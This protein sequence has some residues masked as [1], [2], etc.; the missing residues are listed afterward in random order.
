ME[1]TFQ[2]YWTSRWGQEYRTNGKA[3]EILKNYLD[4]FLLEGKVG[5]NILDIG[6]GAYPISNNF[7]DPNRKQILVD[8][9]GGHWKSERVLKL[10]IDIGDLL[11]KQI[12]RK[13]FLDS[14]RDFFGST[15]SKVVDTCIMGHILNYVDYRAL[16][17]FVSELLAEKGRLLVVNNPKYFSPE[18]PLRK[19]RL[20]SNLEIVNAIEETTLTIEEILL[21]RK[22]GETCGAGIFHSGTMIL[23]AQNG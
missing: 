9:A 13:R 6:C 5:Q 21:L 1:K 8:I 20:K 19:P 23:C 15:W 22:G 14:V 17:P 7:V 10:E 11:I 2:L 3:P 18:A 12:E 4:N 16:I